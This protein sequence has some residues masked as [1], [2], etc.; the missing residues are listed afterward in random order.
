MLRMGGSSDGTARGFFSEGVLEYFLFFIVRTVQ[1]IL[2][3]LSLAMFLR[4]ILSWFV[5]EEGGPL[6]SFLY[7]VTEPFIAPIRALCERFGWFADSP[8]DIPFVMTFLIIMILNT[9][10]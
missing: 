4:A 5:M 2:W 8:M 1:V 10:L 3:A 9:V 6:M 7:A